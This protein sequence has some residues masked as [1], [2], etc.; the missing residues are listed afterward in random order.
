MILK[1][2]FKRA[3]KID[4]KGAKSKTVRAKDKCLNI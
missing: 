1:N 3:G 2:N 4:D